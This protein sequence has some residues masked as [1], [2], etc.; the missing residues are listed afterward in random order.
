M[1]V[2]LSKSRAKQK[3]WAVHIPDKNKTIQFGDSEYADYT[4]HR[5]LNRKREY[6]QRHQA[7]ESW[8]NPLT[9]GF[10][11]RWLLWK[12]PTLAG[13]I[14]DIYQRFQIKVKRSPS[15]RSPRPPFPGSNKTK[16]K[17]CTSWAVCRAALSGRRRGSR[18]FSGQRRL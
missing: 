8:S 5:D 7:R 17:P 6:I 2:F 3:K 14:A 18:R 16:F 13:S 11:S 12:K 9:A 1:E 10:G 15:L 4:A